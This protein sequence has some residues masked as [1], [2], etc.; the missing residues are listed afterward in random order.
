[1][2]RSIT[3]IP[4]ETDNLHCFQSCFSMVTKALLQKDISV[5]DAEIFTDFVAE[6]PTWPYKGIL[7]WANFGLFVT[8]IEDFPIKQF[9]VDPISVIK[10][11]VNNELIANQVI[12]D[13]NLEK[14]KELARRCLSNSNVIFV[15]RMPEIGDIKQIIRT[16]ALIVVNVNYYALLCE[17]KYFGHFVVIY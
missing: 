9:S 10:N 4:N 15:S 11:H 1:M 2:K 17:D 3:L 14:E 7:S 16:E 5:K 6:K 8:I 12:A 13:S